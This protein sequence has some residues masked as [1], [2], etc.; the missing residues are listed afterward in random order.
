MSVPES[1]WRWNGHAGHF[2]GAES[3]LFHLNTEVGRYRVSTVGEWVSPDPDGEGEYARFREIGSRRLF[4]TFV[5]RTDA[6]GEVTD[7]TELDALS[8]NDHDTATANHMALSRKWAA[9]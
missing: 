9:R 1:E 7:Y 2:I 5:F 3:C 4:E 8:A 6:N